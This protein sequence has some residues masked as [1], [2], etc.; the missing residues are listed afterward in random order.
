MRKNGS[1][2]GRAV[3]RVHIQKRLLLIELDE[4]MV[5]QHPKNQHVKR[6]VH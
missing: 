6:A 4:H 3:V 5:Q 2:Q 1:L